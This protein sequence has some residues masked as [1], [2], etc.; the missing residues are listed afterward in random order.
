LTRLER[1]APLWGVGSRSR[2]LHNGRAASLSDAVLA[3]DSEGAAAAQ[4]FREMTAQQRDRPLA[5]L[6]SL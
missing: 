6:R 5:F 2:F 1:L 3:H 4:A